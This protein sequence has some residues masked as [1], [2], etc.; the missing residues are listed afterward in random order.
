MLIGLR[1]PG[2]SRG[3]V[4][5]RASRRELDTGFRRYDERKVRLCNVVVG[6]PGKGEVW[7]RVG[8]VAFSP[9][10]LWERAFRR[11]LAR[12]KLARKSHGGK[13]EG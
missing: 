6:P 13:G 9:R 7:M 8:A 2:E 5:F 12:A 1:H 3:P 11:D 4:F 10:P